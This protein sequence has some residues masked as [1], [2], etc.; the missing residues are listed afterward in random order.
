MKR[1]KRSFSDVKY[2]YKVGM[3]IIERDI[4]NTETAYALGIKSMHDWFDSLSKKEI[5]CLRYIITNDKPKDIELQALIVVSL[6][7]IETDKIEMTTSGLSDM[8][9]VLCSNLVLWEMIQNGAIKLNKRL[10]ITDD[11]DAV[12]P[13]LLADWNLN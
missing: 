3:S 5:K 13:P 7:S 4:L 6:V 2:R 8:I 9:M 10:S 1:K 12:V 11:L